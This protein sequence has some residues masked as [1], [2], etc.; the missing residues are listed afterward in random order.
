MK[1]VWFTSDTHFGHTNI[2]H[3]SNRPFADEV[4]HDEALIENWNAV[5]QDGDD[6]FHLGDVVFANRT[7]ADE[8][9]R[10]LK[11]NKHH[12]RGNH[13]RSVRGLAH[14]FQWVKDLHTIKVGE[15]RVVL[16]H[17]SMEVWNASHHGAWHL[18]GHSH[19]SLPERIAFRSFDVG[20]D[21]VA[22]RLNGVPQGVAAPEG[23]PATDYRPLHF[24]EVSVVMAGKHWEPIDYHTEHTN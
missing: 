7:R 20:V 9:L 5:V 8:V 10:A 4:A 2:I 18:Y 11:G 16:C 12:I 22:A 15:Q 21:A 1:N 19:N 17:Y 24:D 23:L 3:Y 13:D 6:V 14:R